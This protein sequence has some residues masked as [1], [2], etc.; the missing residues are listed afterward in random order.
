L[1]AAKRGEC[2]IAGIHLLDPQ[3]NTYN[4][5]FLNEDLQI[6]P[7]YGR[8]QGIVYRKGDARFEGRIVADAVTRALADSDCVLVNRNRGSGTRIL[9]DRLLDKAHPTGYLTESRSHN[10]VVAAVAQGR[11]DWGVA[12]ATVAAEAQ[13]GFLPLQEE[14]YGFVIPRNRW[15]RP[16]VEAFRQLLQDVDVRK[17]LAEKGFRVAN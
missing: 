14:Q 4:R 13:L 5:P 16:A 10:A 9:I 17:K 11:A 6:A 2:D 3:T 1:T 8:L 12:I 7:G 15:D